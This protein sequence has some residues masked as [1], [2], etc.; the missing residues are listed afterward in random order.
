LALTP[1]QLDRY[2]RHILLKEIGGAGQQALLRTRVLIVGMGGL[3]N[4]LAQYLAAAGVGTLGLVDD[5][6]V[7]LSNLQRQILFETQDIGAR[8]VDAAAA[9]LKALNP[10]VEIICHPQRVDAQN[11]GELVGQYDL[12]ADGCDNFATRYIINDA[13]FHARKTLVSG[14]VGQF[15]GQVATFKPWLRDD[16]NVPLPCYRSLVP[17]PPD[18]EDDG[19]NC[20]TLG[21]VGA[22]AGIIGA[23]QALEIIK[24]ITGS[25]ESL[26]GKV[27]IFDGLQARAR[28]VKLAWD[29]ANP[30]NGTP[31]EG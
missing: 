20:A 14:A 1:T 3:G 22:L 9:R 29:P 5:D 10:D 17:S 28:T 19:E 23:L 25:G 8:K 4:P 13:C 11:A 26:A 15:D 7:D 27:L 18:A 30:L 24:E 16:E 2:K 6:C 12:S 31:N 21:T